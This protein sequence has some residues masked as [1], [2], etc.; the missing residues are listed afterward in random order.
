MN[1]YQAALADEQF[2]AAFEDRGQPAEWADEYAKAMG[3]VTPQVAWAVK[4]HLHYWVL[5]SVAACGDRPRVAVGWCEGS[6]VLG[7][8]V[9]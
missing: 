5:G 6:V 8:V 1:E 9:R 7:A 3:R 4:L 2:H